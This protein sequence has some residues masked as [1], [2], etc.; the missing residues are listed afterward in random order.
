MIKQNNSQSLQMV[1]SGA[2]KKTRHGSVKLKLVLGMSSLAAAISLIMGLVCIAFLNSCGN[3]DG[4]FDAKWVVGALTVVFIVVSVLVASRLTETISGP[5]NTLTERV[6][7]LSEGNLHSK[8]PVMKSNDEISELASTFDDTIKTLNDYVSEIQNV[9][10]SMSRGDF[11]VKVQQNYK[12]D[13]G[14]IRTALNTIVVSLHTMFVDINKS[15]DQV[16]DGAEQ[17]ASG[18]QT[19]AQGATEQAS[20]IEQLSAAIDEIA[21]KARQ[22]AEHALSANQF[23]ES[24]TQEVDRGNEHMKQMVTAMQEI[25]ESSSQIGSIIKSIQSIA[26][27]TNILA[28]NA[29]VEA[30]R[31]GEAGKGFAVVADEVRNLAGKSADAAKNTTALIE[32]SIR[33]VEHG[34]M[35]ADETA[36]SLSAIISSTQQTSKLIQQIA[37][38]ANEQANSIGQVTLGVDQISSVVQNNSATAEESAAT[39][40]ELSSQAQLL[41]ANLSHLKLETDEE[42][43]KKKS[44]RFGERLRKAAELRKAEESVSVQPEEI[45]PQEPVNEVTVPSEPLLEEP[46]AVPAMAFV[47]ESAAVEEPVQET[48]EEAAPQEEPELDG[49]VTFE[50]EQPEQMEPEEAAAESEAAEPE[51]N[52]DEPAA[53]EG[54]AVEPETAESP[55]EP[56]YAESADAEP[57]NEQAVQSEPD[58]SADKY[59]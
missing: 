54:E 7:L 9:L 47:S 2:K 27:Q 19:M 23:A 33:S 30:A 45:A 14:A 1:K 44:A 3:A 17:V 56:E 6:K 46:V 59:E 52:S 4:A 48:A 20:T 55:V 36:K 53:D 34:Q 26:F 28:L 58:E 24:A 18:S 43:A 21:A 22:S 15:A 35:V 38:A 8:V 51:E 32:N 13:F 37:D 57:V 49:Q 11:T 42:I 10:V 39:S 5:I 50:E 12:G 25:G 40:Q 41:K 29:A 31:A 16:A